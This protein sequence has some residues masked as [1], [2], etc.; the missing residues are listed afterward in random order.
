MLNGATGLNK[1]SYLGRIHKVPF[2]GPQHFEIQ[3]YLQTRGE[4]GWGVGEGAKLA[5]VAEGLM[6]ELSSLKFRPWV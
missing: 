4:W 2:W 6:K 3:K 5:N 1:A